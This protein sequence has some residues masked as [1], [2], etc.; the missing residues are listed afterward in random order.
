MGAFQG[1]R[2]IVVG[3]D[4]SAPARRAV[5]FITRLGPPRGGRVLCVS[6]LE[7][8]RL[9]AMPLVPDSIRAVIVGQ[10]RDVDRK[11]LAAAQAELDAAMARLRRAG[12]RA[13][14]EIRRGA[15]LP[16][17]LAGVKA[18]RADLLTLGATGKS[19]VARMLLGS[20]AQAALKRSPVSVLIVP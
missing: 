7:P 10:A 8:T 13:K 16:E 6:V 19:G 4:G 15:P 5:A 14:A 11:R 9:P 17:L 3:L 1:F 12:W 18:I 2:R 20:V